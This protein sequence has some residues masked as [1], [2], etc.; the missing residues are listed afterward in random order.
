M[1]THKSNSDLLVHE[2]EGIATVT[3]NRPEVRNSLSEASLN[4]LL[5]VF[6]NF[7]HQPELRAVI[8]KGRGKVFCSGGDV[9]F[10]QGLLT[11]DND[12]RIRSLRRYIGVAHDVIL[13]MAKISCPIIANV[14]GAAAGYGMSL[15]CLSDIIVADINSRFI[16]AYSALGSTPDGGLSLSLP[17]AIGSRKAFEVLAFN[18]AI[19]AEQAYQWDLVNYVFDGEGTNESVDEIS[20]KIASR[21]ATGPSTV[22]RNLK[23]LLNTLPVSTLSA[24]LDKEL[25]TFIACA[26]TKDFDEGVTAFIE[27]RTPVFL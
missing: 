27:K 16:P 1:T 3:I 24:H 2:S 25:E 13:A 21:L 4:Q 23:K 26:V 19:P 17:T 12:S 9:T 8:L 11:Q 5:E 20:H 6:I 7:Q 10:F 14:H 22:N 15:A 18:T